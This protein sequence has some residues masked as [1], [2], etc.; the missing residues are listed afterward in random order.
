M[1]PPWF[2]VGW[3]SLTG[4]LVVDTQAAMRQT[5]GLASFWAEALGYVK[6][7]GF[8]EPDNASIIDPDRRGPESSWR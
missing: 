6:E 7:P 8:D 2:G 3:G 4:H 5:Q 1:P